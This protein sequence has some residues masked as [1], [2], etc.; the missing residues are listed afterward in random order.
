MNCP[1]CAT[2]LQPTAI[3]PQLPA[4]VCPDCRGLWIASTD[5]WAWLELPSTSAEGSDEKTPVQPAVEAAKARRC[6]GCG[7][8]ALSYPLG[9]GLPFRLDRCGHCNSFWLDRD[10]W[11]ALRQRGLHRRLHTITNEPWQRQLRAEERRATW[12]AIYTARFGADD[13]AEIQRVRAWLTEHPQQAMLLAF[14]TSPD[15]YQP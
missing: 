13:Y 3:E 9:R 15:P 8:I 2:A 10:E 4:H 1:T 11:A 14:L 12:E 5:Y 6:P 7:H